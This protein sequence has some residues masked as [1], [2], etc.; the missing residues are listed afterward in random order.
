MSTFERRADN[1]LET[2]ILGQM[3][4]DAFKS[5]HA[6]AATI[7]N[8]PGKKILD[9]Q[10]ISGWISRKVKQGI[11]QKVRAE[12]IGWT[13]IDESTGQ[14]WP[15]KSRRVAFRLAIDPATI[16]RTSNGKIKPLGSRGKVTRKRVAA[17]P[18]K[19][20]AAIKENLA[21]PQSF[22]TLSTGEQRENL[23][24]HV[25]LAIV[26]LQVATNALMEFTRK[27]T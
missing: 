18:S 3:R 11:I 2:L 12:D 27:H 25:E 5:L 9:A 24:E 8:Q 23:T 16:A 1:E 19:D 21:P 4:M 22:D 6:L 17:G 10:E 20:V 13:V 26:N 14:P 7:P 15:M